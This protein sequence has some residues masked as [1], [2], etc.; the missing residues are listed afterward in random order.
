MAC[1]L[2]EMYQH[3]RGT[4]CHLCQ[5]IWHW[6]QQDLLKCQ[7]A[8]PEYIVLHPRRQWCWDI[9]NI[10]CAPRVESTYHILGWRKE[11]CVSNMV[12]V[13]QQDFCY[14]NNERD[15]RTLK[16]YINRLKEYES[17]GFCS[18][19]G[20]IVVFWVLAFW[21]IKEVVYVSLKYCYSHAMLFGVAT[22]KTVFKFHIIFTMHSVLY[23]SFYFNQHMHYTLSSYIPLHMF[24]LLISHHQGD[25]SI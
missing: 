25:Q 3:F 6:R 18:S 9:L 8:I 20:D 14:K 4:C 12:T 15:G 2:A 13:D 11:I 21:R 23:N 22:K 10:L 7:Y 1:N 17:R 24:R 5:N 19:W 16:T